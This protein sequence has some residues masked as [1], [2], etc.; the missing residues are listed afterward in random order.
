MQILNILPQPAGEIKSIQEANVW[1][2]N[3]TGNI[4]I[5]F[6]YSFSLPLSPLGTKKF[7]ACIGRHTWS[8][9]QKDYEILHWI[10]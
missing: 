3:L 1:I 7:Q 2:T 4:S 8:E 10:L 9:S 6:L 5:I